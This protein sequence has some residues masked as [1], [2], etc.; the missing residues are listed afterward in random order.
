MAPAVR[1]ARAEGRRFEPLP[2]NFSFGEV[3][4]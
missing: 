1:R 4:G 3:A 2:V